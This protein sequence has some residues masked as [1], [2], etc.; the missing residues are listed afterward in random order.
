LRYLRSGLVV[1]V[2]LLLAAALAPR[3]AMA[4][5][6]EMWSLPT[7]EPARCQSCHVASESE[8]TSDPSLATQLNPF[9]TDWK[10]LGRVWNATIA[11]RDS[12]GDG[13]LNG[14]ELGDF[15]GSWSGAAVEDPSRPLQNSNPG[16]ADC[17]PASISDRSWGIL[18][19]VFGEANKI[20]VR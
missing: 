4:T 14:A 18:K 8:L 1:T 12:D 7:Y 20:K 6:T 2:G 19:A 10:D 3:F 5:P 16:V 11:Q 13:C 15:N 9:G 17:T